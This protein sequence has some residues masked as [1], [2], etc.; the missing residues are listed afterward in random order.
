GQYFFAF[1]PRVTGSQRFNQAI[2]LTRK[3]G[4][5]FVSPIHWLRHFC[6]LARSKHLIDCRP[7]QIDADGFLEAAVCP[8]RFSLDK[9]HR[10]AAADNDNWS[11]LECLVF[12]HRADE[13]ESTFAGQGDVGDYQIGIAL[14]SD[15]QS[16]F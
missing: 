10:T 16:L 7:E 11:G 2:N 15:I 8:G 1:V 5:L 3:R 4:R 12:S 13:M 14:A 9:Y 6:L